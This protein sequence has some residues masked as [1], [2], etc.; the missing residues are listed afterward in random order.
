[1]NCTTSARGIWIV[2][3]AMGSAMLGP[4]RVQTGYNLMRDS[5]VSRYQLPRSRRMERENAP[6]EAPE[7]TEVEQVHTIRVQELGI[8]PEA[9]ELGPDNISPLSLGAGHSSVSS[10]GPLH[11]LVV[12]ALR[13]GLSRAKVELCNA[14]AR[15]GA[16]TPH[17][18]A[19]VDAPTRGGGEAGRNCVGSV[20]ICYCQ[21]CGSVEGETAVAS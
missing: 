19:V 4:R 20:I 18:E 12:F 15:F 21:G 11:L 5:C 17:V 1:M 16:R 6:H 10:R 8:D 9:L 7:R 3:A 14:A 2:S 13:A